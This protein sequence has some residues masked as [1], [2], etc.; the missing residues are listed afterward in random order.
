ML[1]L[2]I[3][4]LLFLATH[5]VR[6]FADGWRSEQIARFGELRWKAIYSVLSLAGFF[7]IVWGFGLA[8]ADAASLWQPPTWTRSVAAVLTL[9]AMILLFAGQV[10]GTRIK[11]AI[12]HP[13]MAGT[14]L[15]AAVHLFANGR[16]VHVLLFGLLLIWALAGFAASRRRD[17]LAGVSYPS[18]SLGRD[19]IAAGIGIAVWVFFAAYGHQWLIGSNPWA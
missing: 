6:I 11:S 9:P 8:R 18:G 19:D 3:G 13:M 7:L 5:S 14:A 17:R 4:L 15:W 2:S 10:P 1:V 12:G 16:V